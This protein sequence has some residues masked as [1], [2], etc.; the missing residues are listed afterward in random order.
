[1]IEDLLDAAASTIVAFSIIAAV[2]II[3]WLISWYL[4][5]EKRYIV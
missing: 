1:M 4:F 3:V 2:A 5:V